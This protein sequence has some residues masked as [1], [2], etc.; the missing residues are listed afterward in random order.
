MMISKKMVD[1]IND[2]IKNEFYSS[3]IYL[4]MAYRFEE[5]NLKVFA[6]WFYRQADEERAHAFKFAKYLLDQGAEVKLSSLDQPKSDYK[7]AEEI[8]SI[9]VEHEIFITNKINELVDL[10][11]KDNDH[12]T[13]NFL[14][15]FVEE[16]VEE[17]AS[18]S[19]LLEMVKMASSPSQ[20]FMLEGRL[21]HMIEGK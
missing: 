10:A 8:C 13:F 4:A 16:Q 7:T 6:K 11:K 5:M 14:Q 18:T 1:S 17:V 21:Y 12:A 2:Q 3:W 9:A 19:E 20:L 15:W